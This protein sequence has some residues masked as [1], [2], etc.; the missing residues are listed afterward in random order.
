MP[1]YITRLG[2]MME[3]LVALL[4]INETWALVGGQVHLDLMPWYWKLCPVV[5][6]IVTVMATISAVSH[7]RAWNAKTL[8]CLALAILIAGGMASVTYYYHLHENDNA[9]ASEEDITSVLYAPA[10][11][12]T[13]S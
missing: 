11:E 3:F 6:A 12:R 5:L 2:F 7:E 13:G 8:T 10:S 9:P 4:V 1:P